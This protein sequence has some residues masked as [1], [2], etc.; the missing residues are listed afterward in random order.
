MK[1]HLMRVAMAAA[2]ALS[3]VSAMAEAPNGYYNSLVGKKEG[4]LKTAVYQLVHNFTTVSSYSALPQYFQRTDVYPESRRWWDM[5][6]DIPLYAPSFSGLNR[7]HSFP[8]S[9]WKVGDNVEYTT[10]Y[11]DLNHLYP[12]EAKANQAKSNYPLGTVSAAVTPKFQ[13]GIV[14]VGS[15]TTGEGG[16]SQLVFEPADEYKGDFARTY[17]YMVTCY[18]DLQWNT[19]YSWMMN[20]DLYPTLKGWAIDLLLK[21]HRDDPVS[22]KET[23]RN[24]VVYTIQNNRNPFIDRPELAEYIWGNKKGEAYT[25]SGSSTPTG[26]PVLISPAQGTSL[27]FNEVA[28]GKS[29]TSKLLVRGENLRNPVQVMVSKRTG[30]GDM[31]SIN[32]NSIAASLANSADGYWLTVTYTPTATGKHTGRLVFSDYDDT[33]MSFG[34]ELMGECFPVPTLT[35]CTATEATDITSD[36]YTANWTY[37]E[38]E[39]VDYWVVNRTKYTGSEISTEQLVAEAPGLVIEGF[40]E[41]DKESYTV[42][43]YRLGYLSPESNVIFVDHLGVTGVEAEH[44]LVLQ[45]FE[46]IIRFLCSGELTGVCIYDISGKMVRYIDSVSDHSDIEMQAGVYLVVT[47]QTHR[48]IKVVVQ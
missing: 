27:D 28:I 18:Q 16:G 31:F 33:G 30:N 22:D 45:G 47:D 37:P 29:V 7:E 42:Q 12:S 48:P 10:A 15:P 4:D 2:V 38:N 39:V 43:S 20:R 19:K 24:D 40:N 5:Y 23:N 17:F 36:S 9:W 34:I 8:K 41:C 26:D 46:G 35:A 25:D 3:S 32:V 11:V 13:N 1:K 21:W 44:G 6:S 14:K